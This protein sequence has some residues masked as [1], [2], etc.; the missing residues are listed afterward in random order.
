M[1]TPGARRARR[2]RDAGFDPTHQNRDG[3]LVELPPARA[4]PGR[5]VVVLVH[6]GPARRAP[7][8][9]ACGGG[10]RDP[11]QGERDEEWRAARLE[12]FA[13]FVGPRG[14]RYDGFF[15]VRSP[16]AGHYSRRFTMRA[17]RVLAFLGAL[18]LLVA[19]ATAQEPET[20]EPEKPDVAP[21]LAA[22]QTQ[23]RARRL[24]LPRP[25]DSYFKISTVVFRR[26]PRAPRG[27]RRRRSS[28]LLYTSPSPRDQRGSRMPSSA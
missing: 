25:A 8:A 18:A 3:D 17:V 27:G 14:R 22:C 13:S 11:S 15:C 10:G 26:R 1:P 12:C 5:G 6:H 4:P 24:F 9:D 23:V 16:T 2:A 19:L 7:R 20:T 21:L 28:C